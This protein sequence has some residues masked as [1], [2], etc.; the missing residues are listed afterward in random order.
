MSVFRR[1][2]E[3][4]TPAQGAPPGTPEGAEPTTVPVA[5][6]PDL[7]VPPFRPA[8]TKEAAAMTLPPK[9]GQPTGMGMPP[10]PAPMAG[11]GPILTP[12]G[13]SRPAQAI[14]RRSMVV[15]KGISLQGTV[16]DAE[17]LVVEGTVESQMMQAAELQIAQSGVFKGE[18]EVD[19][20]EIAGIFDGTLTVRGNL[21]I[22]AS[23]K[24]MGIAR[25]RRLQVEEGGQVSGRMEMLG[26]SM[27]SNPRP[28]LPLAA[29]DV[30]QLG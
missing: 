17:R 10:R 6:D 2:R 9:P 8:P 18:V 21:I 30:D 28:A 3:D 13:S 14:E 7:A 26:D 5:R 27:P 20:A 23:G 24:V 12:G 25:C 4:P 1:R 22:R 15:G 11:T 29:S 19:D 16:T